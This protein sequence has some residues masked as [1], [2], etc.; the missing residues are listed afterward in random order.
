[1]GILRTLARKVVGKVAGQAPQRT[2]A[3]AATAT[4]SAPARPPE[5]V[6]EDA[7]SLATMEAGAQEVKERIDAGEPVVLLDVREP[8]ETAGGIIA[9][10]RRIPLGQLPARWQEL[11]DCNEVVCYCA[12]GARSL[13][14]AHFLREQGL[15]NATSMDGGISAW[16]ELGGS[17]VRPS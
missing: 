7:E 8:F 17:I 14:A 6:V 11:K 16:M 5:P 13:Q 2:A 12:V 1:M 4:V 10:A 9:G 3:P 15:F